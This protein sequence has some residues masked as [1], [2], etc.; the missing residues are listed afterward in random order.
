MPSVSSELLSRLGASAAQI[1]QSVALA[2]SEAANLEV[3]FADPL[4]VTAQAGDIFAEHSS[5]RV[6]IQFSFAHLPENPMALLLPPECLS[7]LLA[8]MRESAAKDIDE[9]DLAELRPVLE[10]M[11]QGICLSVGNLL[12]EPIAASGLSIRLQVVNLPP[13]LQQA[14]GLV[15]SNIGISGEGFSG[16]M[17]WLMDNETAHAVCGMQIQDEEA[18]P[19]QTVTSGATRAPAADSTVPDEQHLEI[20]MDIPLDITVELG[21]MRM[22]VREVLDL[23]AGSIVEIDKAA[24]EPV[25]VVVNGRLVARGEVV[26]IDD[27]FGVRITEILSLHDRLQRLSEAS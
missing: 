24:G 2:T 5:V 21:R 23:G 22:Q 7:E 26:V 27:N 17:T 14:E 6:V 15:R 10:A 25:D 20:I 18:S 16:V 12:N 9:A 13:N 3:R 1:W 4:T 8:A 19:F 11:V